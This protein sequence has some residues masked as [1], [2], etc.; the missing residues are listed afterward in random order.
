MA[1]ARSEEH[2][3]AFRS[4]IVGRIRPLK[5]LNNH[6]ARQIIA[7]LRTSL[8]AYGC[9]RGSHKCDISHRE[10]NF[11]TNQRD[12]RQRDK[13]SSSSHQQRLVNQRKIWSATTVSN[14]P[15]LALPSS[16]LLQR[17]L[18]IIPASPR[19]NVKKRPKPSLR[20]GAGVAPH[21]CQRCL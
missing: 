6:R 21:K 20:P 10:R 2:L 5:F 4:T 19:R 1:R 18:A 7:V 16:R 8:I 14:L 9:R 3:R 13:L 12:N 17:N 15:P 11:P